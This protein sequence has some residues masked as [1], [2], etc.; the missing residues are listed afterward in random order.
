MGS[1]YHRAYRFLAAPAENVGWSI[2]AALIPGLIL[3]GIAPWLLR[4]HGQ[5]VT[6]LLLWIG[7]PA[8]EH[9][10]IF[11]LM[12]MV[13]PEVSSYAPYHTFYPAA[14]GIA[15]CAISLILL[16]RY[17]RLTPLRVV[18]G[19]AALACGVSG[20][21]FYFAGDRFPYDT[22]EFAALWTRAEFVIWLI[23]PVLMAIVLGPLPLGPALTFLYSAMTVLYAI[24]FSVIRLT[25]LLTF[26]HVA[27]LLWLPPAYFLTGFLAD[28]LYIVGFYSVAVSRAARNLRARSEVWQW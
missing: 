23:V 26:F 14:V 13:V 7:V 5:W 6:A 9:S 27:G 3:L 28:F 25:L 16:V 18:V 20:A 21:F 22:A 2:L 24:W 12:P 8:I 17:T 4:F 1:T 10:S 19:V 15:G 11:G